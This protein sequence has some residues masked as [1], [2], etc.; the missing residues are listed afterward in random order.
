MS[1]THN[2]DDSYDVVVV[3]SGTGLMGAITAARRGLRTLVVE[4]GAYLGGSTAMSGGGMWLPNNKVL[5]DAGVIDTKERVLTYLDTLVGDTAPRARR[6]AYVANAPAVVNEML[7]ATPVK[8]GHM[9]E[10]ADYFADLEGG[11]AIGRSVEPQPFNVN[12]IGK[13]AAILRTSDAIS[14]PVPM[15]IT[16]R[17]FRSM[18]LMGRRPLQAFPTIFKRVVQGVGGKLL[19]KDMA[20]GGKALA[21]ALIAGARRA[22]VD[23]WLNSPLRELVV[24]D[25]KV[26][27]VVVEK[28][29]RLQRVAA[30]GGVILAVGGFDHNGEKRRKHQS[31]ALTEDWSFGNPDNTGD[32]FAIARQVGA[33]LALLDQAWW[34]PAIPPLKPGGAPIFML[35]ERSLPGSMIVDSTGHRFFNEAADYMTAG[36]A[37]LGLDDDK[38]HHLP[39]W[40]IFDQ[41]Y[42]NRYLFAGAVMPRMPIPKIFYDSGVVVKADSIAELGRKIGV[43]GL[44]DG[45]ARFNLLASQGQ[46][47]DFKRGLGHYDRYYGDPTN[48]PNP[49]LGPITKAPF[50]AVKTVPADLGTCGG[51]TADEWGRALREDGAPID[52]LYAVGNAAAN[53]FGTFYP[54]PGAT[55]GQGVVFAYLAALHAAERARS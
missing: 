35:S 54:G 7:A 16:S 52:G 8:L 18:N 46:D 19:R 6:E 4:K 11:S 47:D 38:G 31:E 25:G 49:N 41:A 9:N 13:D 26:T 48:T 43:P 23:I 24:E 21:A 37:M 33:G 36:R 44:V 50:Y 53:A 17:D 45:A 42:R 34:F 40:L 22:G 3:G 32:L 15:P 27:G 5:Q 20:A 12:S 30:K 39:M 51:I 1:K 28:D 10:Y 29:G 55:I 14:A 2:W